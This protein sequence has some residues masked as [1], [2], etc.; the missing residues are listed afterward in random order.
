MLPSTK[1]RNISHPQITG[2]R[3]QLIQKW[4]GEETNYKESEIRIYLDI[5]SLSY[6]AQYA[7]IMYETSTKISMTLPAAS[8]H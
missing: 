1:L 7:K 2:L 8:W 5:Y 4:F 3:L 6:A